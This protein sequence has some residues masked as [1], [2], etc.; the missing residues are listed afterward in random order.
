M[1]LPRIFRNKDVNRLAGGRGRYGLASGVHCAAWMKSFHQENASKAG[2]ARQP[3]SAICFGLMPSCATTADDSPTQDHWPGDLGALRAEIDRIDS[4]I[5]DLLMRRAEVVGQVAATKKNGVALRPGR[6]AAILRR[7]L[8]RHK[9]GLPAQ[10]VVRI[11]REMLAGT[12]AMQGGFVVAVRETDPG[13]GFVAAAREQFGALTPLRVHG[14]S[15]QAIADVSAGRASV[16]VLPIPSETDVTRDAWWTALLQKD[17]PRIHVVGRLPFWARRTEGAPTAQAFAVA[18]IAP[19]PSGD[20]RSLL[21]LELDRDLSRARLGSVLAAAG[22]EPGNVILRRDAGATVAHS[23]VEVAGF[24][25]DEDPRLARLGSVLRSPVVIGA[26][27]VP[28]GA[29]T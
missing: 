24:V 9:G 8:A 14:S 21:G 29:E 12:T 11:W 26:Y 13:S 2:F 25:A 5:H 10:A 23:L 19:D 27:A 28:V 15:A 16:A 1:S 18:A 17:E 6:E 3:G 20:D 4:D 7:L 22:F